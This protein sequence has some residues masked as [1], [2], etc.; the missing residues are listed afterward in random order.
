MKFMCRTLPP[1]EEVSHEFTDVSEFK[2]WFE[3]ITGDD[4]VHEYTFVKDWLPFHDVGSV[5]YLNDILQPVE[6]MD[7]EIEIRCI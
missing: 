1:W 2:E 6:R 3:K 4:D 5:L 7:A